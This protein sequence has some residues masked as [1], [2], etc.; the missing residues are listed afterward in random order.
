MSIDNQGGL[1]VPVT[2]VNRACEECG[3][4]GPS[5]KWEAVGMSGVLCRECLNKV[6]SQIN[7]A[8]AATA[9]DTTEGQGQKES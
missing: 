2:R 9:G 7:Q 4:P 5:L 1:H 3:K 6:I 8:L